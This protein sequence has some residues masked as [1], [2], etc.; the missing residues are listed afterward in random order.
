VYVDDMTAPLSS[1]YSYDPAHLYRVEF[2][3]SLGRVHLITL[4][5][6]TH[7]ALTGWNPQAICLVCERD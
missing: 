6:V 5:Y 4:R 2:F 7:M 3:P 1:I